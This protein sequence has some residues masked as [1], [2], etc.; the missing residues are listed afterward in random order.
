[1]EIRAILLAAGRGE[2]MR[3]L[4]DSVPKAAVPILDVP[5]G[6]WG[7]AS[8][9]RTVGHVVVNASWLSAD[10]EAALGGA[11]VEILQEHPEPYGTGGTLK[12]LEPR[13]GER[14]LV[15][16]C[17]LL[18]DLDP[19]R[20]LAAHDR[21]GAAGTIAVVDV[22][23]GADLVYDD[24]TATRFVDRRREDRA[25]A[26]YIGVAVLERSA[27]VRLPDARP[28]G[29]GET[30]LRSLAESGEL[31]VHV[32]PG[33]ERDVGTPAA[34]LRASLDVLEGRAPSPPAELPGELLEVDGGRAYL[35]PG[36]T[37]AVGSLGPGAIVL[38]G[39]AVEPGARVERAIVW[40]DVSLRSGR[41]VSGAI[42]LEDRDLT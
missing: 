3:P 23:A 12:A 35:G 8:L 5:M 18:T 34:L 28:L 30:L 29:L 38:A 27:I 6:A 39:A 42:A 14:V 26:R 20:L 17:D 11:D 41:E 40:R 25:G 15:H 36:A 10:V 19:G 21:S 7:L 33:Y 37:A 2:R 1:M 4:T 24:G 16:N 31:A 13:L 32:H 9:R 22:P